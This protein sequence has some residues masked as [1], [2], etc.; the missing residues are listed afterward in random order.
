I[1]IERKESLPGFAG[2]QEVPYGNVGETK[3]KG[4]DTNVEYN[5]R[6]NKDWNLVVRG[7][8]TWAK[9]EWV[10]NDIPDKAYPWRNQRGYGMT[11]LQG[12]TAL[13][14]Y[15]QED[16]DKITAWY[17]LPESQRT[18]E[19]QPFPTPYNVGLDKVRAGDIKYEDKN[20]DGRISDDDISWLGNGD[21]PE[22]TYG[23]G[24]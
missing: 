16:I 19:N 24:F 4:L 12:F 13:G 18:T 6:F 1:L 20:K 21:V 22:I 17:N 11:S 9:P 15:T 23:F 14:L 8:F 5:K 7:N 2:F 3:T 10:D